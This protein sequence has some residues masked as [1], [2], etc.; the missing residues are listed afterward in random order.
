M[1]GRLKRRAL[2]TRLRRHLY[3]ALDPERPRRVRTRSARYAASIAE[4]LG[5][6]E[7]PRHCTWCH[8]RLRLQRHHWDYEEPINV[9]FLCGDCHSLAD[10]MVYAGSIA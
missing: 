1:N 5:L 7:R 4:S 6:I 2:F 8:R 3:L 9:T 10:S